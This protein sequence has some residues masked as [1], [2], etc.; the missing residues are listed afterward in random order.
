MKNLVL[1]EL[2]RVFFRKKF[3]ALIIVSSMYMM[4]A[5]GLILVYRTGFYDPNTTMEVDRLSFAVHLLRDY[6]FYF[7]IVLFPIIFVECF[8]GEIASGKFRMFMTRPYSKT[9]I[10]LSKVLVGAI[11]GGII[12]LVSLIIFTVL[13]YIKLPYVETTRFF[14]ID[15]EFNAIGAFIYSLKFY[16]LEW[17]ILM[18]L[19][20]VIATLSVLIRNSVVV[21]LGTIA[22][23]VFTL[24]L[25]EKLS[26]FIESNK[27]IFDVLSGKENFIIYNILV[28][29]VGIALTVILFNKRD[30]LY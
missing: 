2:R 22:S 30:Y 4:V 16:A 24:Y 6:H 26:Y 7:L 5:A 11:V 28:I 9:K 25:S 29:I 8:C 3:L 27:A 18:G 14:Y 13:G 20:S 1:S 12:L 23:I 10:I 17:F 21:F 19:M 15:K